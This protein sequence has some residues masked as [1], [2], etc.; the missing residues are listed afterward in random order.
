MP[1]VVDHEKRKIEIAQATF[2]A[3]QTVGLA[4]I[5]LRDIAA[6]AGFTTGVFSNYF[7][8]KSSVLRFAFGIAYQQ[9]Y[10]RIIE[11]NRSVEKGV[12]CIK[13]AMVELLPDQEHPES[14]AFVSM[15]FGMRTSD[16]PILANQYQNDKDQYRGLLREYLLSAIKNKEIP[17]YADID[18]VLDLIEAVV[19]G[20]CIEALLNPE[21]RTK[22][23]CIRVIDTMIERLSEQTL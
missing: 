9:T 2:I 7:R 15:C 14:V 13:N 12:S 5:T 19:D 16:D 22:K 23:R 4:N 3:V 21:V 8:D 10:Q 18:E 6:E 1:K 11:K 20:V 17:E